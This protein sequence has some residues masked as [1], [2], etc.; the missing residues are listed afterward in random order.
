MAD[1]RRR[2]A[3]VGVG[4]LPFRSRHPDRQFYELAYDAGRLALDDAGIS[5][6]DVDTM[7]HSIYC[8]PMM[9]QQIADNYVQDYLGLADKEGI[10]VAAG[11]STGGHAFRAAYAEVMSGLSDV[12]LLVGVQKSTDV[13]DPVTGDR[14]DGMMLAQGLSCDMTWCHPFTVLPPAMWAFIVQQ[15]MERW[16]TTVEQI[17]MAAVKAHDNALTNPYAQLRYPLTV[18]QVLNS[19]LIA[20]PHTMYMCCLYGE[21]ACGIVLMSEERA[22][23]LTDKPVWVAGAAAVSGTTRLE[24]PPELEGRIPAVGA[25]ADIAY[26]RAGITDPEDAFDVVEL[27]DITSGIELVTYEEL[28]LCKPG[29]SGRLIDE[30]AVMKSGRI[31]VN[32][33]GGRVA[34]GHIAG[35]SEV[36]SIGEVALQLREQA[37]ERQVNVTRGRGVIETMGSGIASQAAVIVLEREEAA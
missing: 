16:G 1:H 33:S 6:D 30:G 25:A 34:C 4:Q 5:V 11:A 36:Y 20:W 24:R 27:H 9:R 19:R 28:R 23:E 17:A 10:R 21:G 12:V 8:E 3:V 37:A 7:F 22:R 18:E 29:E 15:H 2:V 31:P 13:V 14:G 35:V 26:E 32:P